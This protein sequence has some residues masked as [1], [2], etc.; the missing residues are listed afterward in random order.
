LTK[1]E[2]EFEEGT[3]NEFSRRARVGF[4]RLSKMVRQ[5]L[6]NSGL[7]QKQIDYIVEDVVKLVNTATTKDA[8]H[9]GNMRRLWE[10]AKK[11]GYTARGKDRIISAFLSRASVLVPKIRQKVLT[12]L[13]V[14]LK[15]SKETKK[16]PT[17]IPSGGS[18]QRGIK[19]GQK[20]E[21]EKVDW[22]KTSERDLLDGKVTY[23]K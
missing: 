17:R 23:K 15:E 6:L 7:P 2:R 5:P 9:M 21:K 14:S 16:E 18:V 13:K 4:S 11:E 1:R 19:P 12:E 10:Q 22:S 20:I 3:Y 8:R